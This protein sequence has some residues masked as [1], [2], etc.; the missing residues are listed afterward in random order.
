M[1]INRKSFSVLFGSEDK[2]STEN[3]L[4][5]AT[6]AEAKAARDV[7]YREMKA[8]GIACRRSVLKGQLRQYWAWGVECGRSCDV[9]EL[10]L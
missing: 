2:P 7:A 3:A 8:Q 10:Y 4:A 9:Y 5:Y 1:S 6:D